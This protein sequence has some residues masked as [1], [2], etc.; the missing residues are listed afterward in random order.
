MTIGAVVT[1]AIVFTTS[2]PLD[3]KAKAA[4]V[5]YARQLPVSSIEAGLPATRLDEWL[6]R[7]VGANHLAWFVSG[8]D[9]KPE[10]QAPRAFPL[11]VGAEVG[12][13]DPI[14]LRFHL[15]VGNLAEGVSGKAHV[16]PQSFAD[17]NPPSLASVDLI[18]PFEHLSVLP[19]VVARLRK[20]C[21]QVAAPGRRTM[22]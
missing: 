11:C 8:C 2:P 13:E 10:K 16:L 3:A 21:P 18:E 1:A 14:Y 9:L 12:E 15:A 20:A 4:I 22:R 7:A 19:E 5:E 6:P 17:C